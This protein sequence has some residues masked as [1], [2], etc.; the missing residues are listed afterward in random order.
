MSCGVASTWLPCP[1][2]PPLSAWR[3][4]SRPRWSPNS[5]L[6]AF[7]DKQI[8]VYD[9]ATRSVRDVTTQTHRSHRS[10]GLLITQRSHFSHRMR[11]LMRIPSSPTKTISTHGSIGSR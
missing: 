1:H 11:A 3:L 2:P 4:E 9:P 6:L 5:K 8:K 10:R 7:I